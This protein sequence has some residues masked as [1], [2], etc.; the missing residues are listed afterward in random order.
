M[1]EVYE[2]E[3]DDVPVILFSAEIVNAMSASDSIFL[4]LPTIRGLV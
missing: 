2:A 4:K 1:H 3:R